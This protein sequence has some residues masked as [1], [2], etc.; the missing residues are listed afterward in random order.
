[1]SQLER[2]TEQILQ[3]QDIKRWGG[4]KLPRILPSLR[5][6]NAARLLKSPIDLVVGWNTFANQELAH[7]AHEL[8]AQLIYY[9]HGSAWTANI[10]K[11]RTA[12]KLLGSDLEVICNSYAAERLLALRWG[13]KGSTT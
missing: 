7:T 5:G 2:S 6:R 12:K 10:Q 11:K 4:I 8:G 13:Y 3:R 9:E 1:E